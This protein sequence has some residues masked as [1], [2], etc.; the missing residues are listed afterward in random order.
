MK[1][2]NRISI[3]LDLMFFQFPHSQNREIRQEIQKYMYS[4]GREKRNLDQSF[5]LWSNSSS[6]YDSKKLMPYYSELEW[7]QCNH[8][9]FLDLFLQK[10]KIVWATDM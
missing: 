8:T 10:I 2:K 5:G 9:H 1:T 6:Q 7:L 4:G 3:V